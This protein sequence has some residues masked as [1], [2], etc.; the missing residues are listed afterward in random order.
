MNLFQ[1]LNEK[2]NMKMLIDYSQFKMEQYGI[3]EKK[4]LVKIIAQNIK[5]CKDPVKEDELVVE[6]SEDDDDLN[7]F[8]F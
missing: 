1:K 4:E 6:G 7:Q 3:K 2:D 8:D 5:E